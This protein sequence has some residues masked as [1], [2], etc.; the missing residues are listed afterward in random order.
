MMGTG[1][2]TVADPNDPA[3]PAPEPALMAAPVVRDRR[4]APLGQGIVE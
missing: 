1:D 2:S 3:E 4:N